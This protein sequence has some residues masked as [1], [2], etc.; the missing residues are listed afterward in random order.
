MVDGI[1]MN[2]TCKGRFN[3]HFTLAGIIKL[4][5]QKFTTVFGSY[6]R[7]SYGRT[8][9]RSSFSFEISGS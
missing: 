3:L 6:V 2:Q 5:A 4:V 7:A 9:A 8:M 1:L